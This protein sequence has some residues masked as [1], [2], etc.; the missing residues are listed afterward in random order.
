MTRGERVDEVGEKDVSVTMN[1]WVGRVQDK[2][3]HMKHHLKVLA[4]L[5][6]VFHCEFCWGR[7][8]DWAREERERTK[9]GPI[10]MSRIMH[11]SRLDRGCSCFLSAV[12]MR[13]NSHLMSAIEMISSSLS[14][15][16]AS[17]S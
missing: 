5:H 3:Q 6:D 4:E 12:M 2:E 8:E 9:A 15:S 11:T 10:P 17:R 13:L 1:Q 7:S 16:E 14:F